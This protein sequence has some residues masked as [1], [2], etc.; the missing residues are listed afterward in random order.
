MKY[1]PLTNTPPKKQQTFVIIK[2]DGVQRNLVGEII[3]RFE[4]TGLKIVGMKMILAD[5]ARLTTHYGK[6]DEWCEQKGQGIVSKLQEKGLPVEKDAIE[7]GKDIIRA[8]IKYMSCSPV[9]ALVLEGNEAVSVIRKI[10]GSTEPKTSDVGTIRGDY[11]I[12]SYN[13]ANVDGRA[14]RNIIHCTEFPHEAQGEIDIWFKPEE[15]YSYRHVNE[16]IL[17]DVNLDGLV[18]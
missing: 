4:K 1:D 15:L 16:T 18:E 3:G 12:D 13:I 11:A 10:A 9:I 6:S 17:Y 14:V 7:Y 5:E 8:L 2:P